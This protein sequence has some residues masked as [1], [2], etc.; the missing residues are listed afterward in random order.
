MAV[1][2]TEWLHV[3][4]MRSLKHVSTELVEINMRLA[5]KLYRTN[6]EGYFRHEF[7]NCQ[8]WNTCVDWDIYFCIK[9]TICFISILIPWCGWVLFAIRYMQMRQSQQFRAITL[10]CYMNIKTGT[11]STHQF[12]RHGQKFVIDMLVSSIAGTLIKLI[13]TQL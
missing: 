8:L 2:M 12:R 5:H 7:V 4:V 1:G 6:W 10:K 11:I 9:Y 13:F 3:L